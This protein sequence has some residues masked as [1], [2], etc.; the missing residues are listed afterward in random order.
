M[1]GEKVRKER[2]EQEKIEQIKAS[3]VKSIEPE[4]L[5]LIEK[6][7]DELRKAQENFNNQL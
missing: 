3:T 6:N 4:I 7:K 2:W 5:K 1:A